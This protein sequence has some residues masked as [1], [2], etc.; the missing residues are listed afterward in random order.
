LSKTVDFGGGNSRLKAGKKG[1]RHW[2]L[3]LSGKFDFPALNKSNFAP[4]FKGSQ[5]LGLDKSI[6]AAEKPVL[7]S[8]NDF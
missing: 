5:I 2:L 1:K 3:V 7:D 6:F 4:Y 8:K